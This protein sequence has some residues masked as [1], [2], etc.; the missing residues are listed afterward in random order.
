[1]LLRTMCQIIWYNSSSEVITIQIIWLLLWIKILWNWCKIS[2]LIIVHYWRWL[3]NWL[4]WR[5]ENNRM[6]M[7]CSV[8]CLPNT[9]ILLGLD[10]FF[11]DFYDIFVFLELACGDF[12]NIWFFRS[13]LASNLWW[14]SWSYLSRVIRDVFLL[15]ISICRRWWRNWL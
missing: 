13:L 7:V 4:L 5:T 15:T 11:L 2:I 9:F 10:R 3:S 14:C 12:N 1:M 8:A 6:R